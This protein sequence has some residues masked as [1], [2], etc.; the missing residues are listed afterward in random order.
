MASAALGTDGD[1]PVFDNARQAEEPM[2]LI[3]EHYNATTADIDAGRYAPVFDVDT[4]N[5]EV[6]WEL[7]Y[8][9]T[10]SR[11]P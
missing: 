1:R 8:G 5:D 4:R 10:A 2:G 3:M 7:C 11:R 6:M 9:L